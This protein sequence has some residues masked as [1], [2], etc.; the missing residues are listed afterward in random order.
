MT[1]N[2]IYNLLIYCRRYVDTL[3]VSE[4]FEF[5]ASLSLKLRLNNLE[6]LL[7]NCKLLS[8]FN[9]IPT[10]DTVV[11]HQSIE[12]GQDFKNLLKYRPHVKR[13]VL[14]D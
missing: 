12:N 4:I 3:I 5:L 1:C 10:I 14:G 7:R 8:L 11:E 13:E 9:L 2:D 6:N